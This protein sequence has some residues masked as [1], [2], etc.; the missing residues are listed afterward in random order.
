MMIAL[1]THDG[2]RLIA[3]RLVSRDESVMIVDADVDGHA[4]R[5]TFTADG[6]LISVRLREVPGPLRLVPVQHRARWA[7]D[8]E[9]AAA[10]REHGHAVSR[11][12]A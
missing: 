5:Y 11:E 3:G 9:N 12:V 1:T 6:G 7:T 2:S 10:T 4:L 8:E